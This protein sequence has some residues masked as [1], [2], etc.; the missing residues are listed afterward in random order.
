[1]SLLSKALIVPAL[2]LGGAAVPTPQP[3][4]DAVGLMVPS[5][6]ELIAEVQ[7]RGLAGAWPRPDPSAVHV[8]AVMVPAGDARLV[9]WVDRHRQMSRVAG[10]GGIAR[11]FVQGGGGLEPASRTDLAHS[12]AT[13]RS[14]PPEVH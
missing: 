12:D 1:M 2:A 11:V 9:E 7:A 14:E 8:P 10:A 3:V 6:G 5:H 4:E 13:D